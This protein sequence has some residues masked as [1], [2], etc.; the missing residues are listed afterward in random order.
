MTFLGIQFLVNGFLVGGVYALLA[1]GVVFIYRA[2]LVFNF[3]IGEMMIFGAL[4]TW[5]CIVALDLP[6]F[7]ALLVAISSSVGLGLVIERL[8]MRPLI[9]QPILSSIMATLGLSMFLKGVVSF[10]WGTDTVSFPN[11]IF[12]GKP[13]V[14]KGVILSDQLL[15]GFVL[16]MVIFVLLAAFFEHSKV[17]LGMRTTAEDHQLAQAT[18][19]N[20]KRIFAIAWCVSGVIASLGGIL[21]GGR[22]GLGV[23]TTPLVA[24]KV[25]PAI[26]FGGLDSILGAVVG[27]LVVGILENVA[28]G[29]IDPK[30]A[31][32]TPYIVLLLVLMFRPEGL[33]GLKRIERV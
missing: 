11:K 24:F 8:L 7:V 27:G 15:W 3:A 14:I 10:A 22:I 33:F 32:I 31:E 26:L 2:T 28:G 25:F 23:V 13:I 9:G 19:I 17:G 6:I 16:A 1:V 20:V 29:L 18:G 21:L 30:I 12:P 4:V 5:S